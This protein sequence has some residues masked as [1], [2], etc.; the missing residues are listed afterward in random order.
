MVQ[1]IAPANLLSPSA[2]ENFA[3]GE[4]AVEAEVEDE[5]DVSD[6]GTVW[7]EVCEVAVCEAASIDTTGLL[8]TQIW[9]SSKVLAA[10]L[11]GTGVDA[12]LS[13]NGGLVPT[14]AGARCL[15]L[16]AGTGLVSLVLAALGAQ[17]TAT[18]YHTA[19][20]SLVRRSAAENGLAA[21]L[22]TAVLDWDDPET[23][24]P[25]AQ[26]ASTAAATKAGTAGAVEG[27]DLIIA[28]DC[29]YVETSSALVATLAAHVP[30]GCATPVLLGYQHRNDRAAS[31]FEEMLQLGFQFRRFE[32]AD[33]AAIP[34]LAQTR[35]HAGSWHEMASSAGTLFESIQRAHFA[36]DGDEI[37]VQL[38]LVTRNP[39]S[40]A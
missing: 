20:L 22:D 10:Y 3:E 40:A 1:L 31:F 17:V 33:D 6:D 21:L 2:T 19:I 18:D 15:E 30:I 34:S 9:H 28:A 14:L 25:P 24:V 36:W 39:I 4:A 12:T 5:E 23:F 27:F 26:E 7:R 38:L 13:G 32:G 37:P 11:R 35:S 8:G 16:G 29:V